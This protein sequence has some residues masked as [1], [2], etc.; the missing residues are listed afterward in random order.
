MT[1]LEPLVRRLYDALAHGEA[2]ALTELLDP[3]FEA[4]FAEGLPLGIGG[5]RVGPEAAIRDGWWAI[6]R[7]YKLRAEPEEWI[8]TSDGR[9]LVLGVYR[10]H[11]RATGA[12]VDAAFAHLWAG[13][14]GR[15]V[16]LRQLT[17]TAR[18]VAALSDDAA[19]RSQA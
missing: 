1:D 15:L 16:G 9:L 4:R 12:S 17:D 13:R 10:G 5:R 18:W 6:G 3:E 19:R 2:D 7:S 11:A 14:R 8:P